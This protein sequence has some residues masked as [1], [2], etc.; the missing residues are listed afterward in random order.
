MQAKTELYKETEEHFMRHRGE[1]SEQHLSYRTT[2]KLLSKR[3]QRMSRDVE[4]S[5][6]KETR[7]QYRNDT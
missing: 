7:R 5:V 1:T 4:L 6:K 3:S 2:V